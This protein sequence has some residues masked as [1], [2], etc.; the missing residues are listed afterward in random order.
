MNIDKSLGAIIIL[1]ILAIAVAIF[2]Q[3][4]FLKNLYQEEQAEMETDILDILEET[5]LEAGIRF[6]ENPDNDITTIV[7]KGAM[8]FGN[9]EPLPLELDLKMYQKTVPKPYPSVGEPLLLALDDFRNRMTQEL[10]LNYEIEYSLFANDFSSESINLNAD[11][12]VGYNFGVVSISYRN[13]ESSILSRL[14]YVIMSSFGFILM[15]SASGSLLLRKYLKEKKLGRYK[16][17]FINNLTHQLQTPLTISGLALEKLNSELSLNEG[18]LKYVNIIRHEN[19]RIKTLS[20]R[21]LKLAELRNTRMDTTS[22]RVHSCI[23]EVLKWHKPMLDEGD[24]LTTELA[25]GNLYLNAHRESLIDI[26]DILISNAIKYSPSPRVILVR[27]VIK[28]KQLWLTVRDNGIGIPK[29]FHEKIFEPFFK[30][31]NDMQLDSH[32]LGLSY[33]YEIVRNMGGQISVTSASQ[34]GTSIDIIFSYENEIVV[35]GG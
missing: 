31:P 23:E 9:E 5:F 13:H 15:I 1:L 32:G 4:L 8:I 33:L 24:S 35:S 11:L 20:K 27:T 3:V 10:N 25:R 30:V 29:M 22:V 2:F 28:E 21:I 16:N 6:T 19:E 34:E 14:K 18:L 12:I 7:F 17:E 26:L